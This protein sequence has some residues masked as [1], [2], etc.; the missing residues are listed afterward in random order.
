MSSAR[1]T[2]KENEIQINKEIIN[3]MSQTAKE[4]LRNY[5][6]TNYKQYIDYI[7]NSISY[8]NSTKESTLNLAINY[9]N[10][11]GNGDNP[12]LAAYNMIDQILK[13]LNSMKECLKEL[14]IDTENLG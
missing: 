7:N 3:T 2:L 9:N 12:V 6:T 5:L 10:I 4:L 13:Y 1:A 14:G 8:L 11:N